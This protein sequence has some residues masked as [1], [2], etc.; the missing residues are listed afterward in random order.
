M[1]FGYSV[2][3]FVTGAELTYRL[4][5]ALSA[6]RGACI[7]Y[8]E[9]LTELRAMEEAFIQTGNLVRSNM[10]TR[11]VINA[12]AC[13]ALSSIDTIEK[14]LER[15]M[16]LQNGLGSVKNSL[17]SSWAKVGWQLYKK[18]EL[19][20]LK[21]QLH[22]RL[23]SIN[24][25][26]TTASNCVEVPSTIAKYQDKSTE[27]TPNKYTEGESTQSPTLPNLL[28]YD[29]PQLLPPQIALPRASEQ[30]LDHTPSST[31]AARAGTVKANE[32]PELDKG[33]GD[34]EQM[35][36]STSLR[37]NP[38]IQ[39]LPPTRLPTSPE[40][41]T[42]KERE[43]DKAVLRIEKSQAE[44]EREIRAKIETENA[45]AAAAAE[46]AIADAKLRKNIEIMT[47]MIASLHE[48]EAAREAEAKANAE[49]ANE[50][51]APIRFKDAV[52]RKFSFPFD[53]CRTWQGI[54]DLIKQAFLHVDIIGPHVQNGHY[55]L[56]GPGGQII[57]PQIWERVIQPDWQ[58]SMHMWPMDRMPPERQRPQPPPP[59]PRP[60]QQQPQHNR[61]TGGHMPMP[62]PMP[63]PPPPPPMVPHSTQHWHPHDRPEIP[64]AEYPVNDP[65]NRNKPIH[66]DD[67][68]HQWHTG[69]PGRPR[70]PNTEYGGEYNLERPMDFYPQGHPR[71]GFR[72]VKEGV[73]KA[74]EF[75]LLDRFDA[76]WRE[77]YKNIISSR[78]LTDEF[79]RT[80]QLEIITFL[81]N[82]RTS[83][84]TQIPKENPLAVGGY[85]SRPTSPGQES[86][87][88]FRIR[89]RRSSGSSIN[90][91]RKRRTIFK[92]MHTESGW[93][94]DE[95]E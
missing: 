1:S 75:E 41:V 74:S 76:N 77:V 83:P 31:L 62:M 72:N 89:N 50:V 70:Q 57:L 10:F 13:I 25:L 79:I 22:Q 55:D 38:S 23:S 8:Q 30:I 94:T 85:S 53:E 58:V 40:N 73:R 16:A 56:I 54:E 15:T 27:D 91:R 19:H 44:L 29:S 68:S 36:A 33:I 63:G 2:G 4:V 24:T 35:D 48:K 59:P 28:T 12:I 51:K 82:E 93:Q 78:G 43:F 21:T 17:D 61:P 64:R 47:Q 90:F 71:S 45:E 49:K 80:H 7:E 9:A 18:E 86:E 46:A 67:D 87:R 69:S 42:L 11:D 52:G 65:K 66:G 84:I 60:T 37:Q 20:A 14:F 39:K 81:Q 92:K 6:S 34:F 95:G 26:I 88:C 3:D 5:R 32:S